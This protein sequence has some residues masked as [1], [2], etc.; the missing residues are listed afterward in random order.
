M[1][2]RKSSKHG[3]RIVWLN[4]DLSTEL[5]CKKKLEAGMGCPG[6]LLTH[7]LSMQGWRQESLPVMAIR[8]GTR[9]LKKG[10]CR[11][12]HQEGQGG[13]REL[14]TSQPDLS[15]WAGYGAN[16]SGSLF[17]AQKMWSL[18]PYISPFQMELAYELIWQFL[19]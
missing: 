3:R 12:Q 6:G 13:S 9:W 1:I 8:V 7:Y 19:D 5:K 11:T 14:Q 17:L 2:C 10:K 16:P 18:L 4:R 15:T